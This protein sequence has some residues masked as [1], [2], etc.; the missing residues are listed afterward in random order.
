MKTPAFLLLAALIAA[1]CPRP[2]TAT[3]PEIGG[4][5]TGESGLTLNSLEA[6]LELGLTYLEFSDDDLD[7]TY[8]H[9]PGVSAGA[10]FLMAPRV[11]T[12]FSLG[13]GQKSGDPFYGLPGFDGGPEITLKTVPFLVGLKFDLASSSRLRVQAG[14]ALMLAYVREEGIAQLDSFGNLDD[15]PV[16][17]VLSGY[18]LTF[19]PE[20]VLG[21]RVRAVGLEVGYGGVKGTLSNDSHSHDIDLTGISARMY[22]VLGL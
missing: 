12:F 17:N 4:K 2:A 15:A 5:A 16:D 9:L 13:Y 7:A 20:W 6:E 10:S 8:G 22:L 3:D 14:G 18:Q 1:A 21:H 19:A 11:R